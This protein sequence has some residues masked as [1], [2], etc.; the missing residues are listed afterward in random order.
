M[1]NPFDKRFRRLA[2]LFK[3]GL[4][5]IPLLIVSIFLG[6]TTPSKILATLA[7]L[8]AI[9]VLV[10]F[11]CLTI[12]HWKSRYRGDHSDIWGIIL[13]V[14]TSSWFKLIYLFRHMIPDMRKTGRYATKG[15]PTI[16]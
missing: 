8:C 9:P 15:S 1:M 7:A 16:A 14:E 3:I 11:Y 10:Y 12:L 6:D 2:R 5:A 4:A 13:L